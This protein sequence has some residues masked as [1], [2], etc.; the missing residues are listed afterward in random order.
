MTDGK[1]LGYRGGFVSHSFQTTLFPK[2]ILLSDFTGQS[3]G[4]R[5]LVLMRMDYLQ[6]KQDTTTPCPL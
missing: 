3:K 5:F 2:E 4:P 1:A 6:T